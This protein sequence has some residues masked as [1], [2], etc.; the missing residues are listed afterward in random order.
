MFLPFLQHLMHDFK[1]GSA[2]RFFNN[3]SKTQ[4]N[5]RKKSS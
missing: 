4:Y 2:T 1:I 5:G 3:A